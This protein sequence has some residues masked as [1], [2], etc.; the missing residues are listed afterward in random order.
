MC[1]TA[2][3]SCSCTC[4][5]L[6]YVL[7]RF[8]D[9]GWQ[10]LLLAARFCLVEVR[11]SGR[12]SSAFWSLSS[13]SDPA[14]INGHGVYVACRAQHWASY[15]TRWH[16]SKFTPRKLS[17][18]WSGWNNFELK[19]QWTQNYLDIEWRGWKTIGFQLQR[20]HTVSELWMFLDDWRFTDALDWK[21]VV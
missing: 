17:I 10:C 18:G 5:V 3:W 9:V 1:L 21:Q 4:H 8:L 12:F 20:L 15:L 19:Q 14:S 6:I 2:D 11:R 16:S 13:V 7:W